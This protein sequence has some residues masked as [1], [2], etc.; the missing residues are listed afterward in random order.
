[1]SPKD[2][3]VAYRDVELSA[4]EQRA[5]C[6]KE[7]LLPGGHHDAFAQL[8]EVGDETSVPYLIGALRWAPAPKAGGGVEC[9]WSHCEAALRRITNTSF[10]LGRKAWEQWWAAHGKEPRTRWLWDGFVARGHKLDEQDRK[11]TVLALLQAASDDEPFS[12]ANAYYVL[13]SLFQDTEVE[14]GLKTA[15]ASEAEK[16]RKGAVLVLALRKERDELRSYLDDPSSAVSEMARTKMDELPPPPARPNVVLTRHLGYDIG[17]IGA[18]ES[19]QVLYFGLETKQQRGTGSE[20]VA[21]SLRTKEVIWRFACDDVVTSV[22]KARDGKVYLVSGNHTV[23]C[24]KQETGQLTWQTRIAYDRRVRPDNGL[25]L[26]DGRLFLAEDKRFLCID[27]S[28]GRVVWSAAIDPTLSGFVWNEAAIFVHTL[29]NELCALSYEGQ[30]LRRA[31]VGFPWGGLALDGDT[32]YYWAEAGE[33]DS[34]TKVEIVACD[35]ATFERRWATGVGAIRNWR[36]ASPLVTEDSVIASSDSHVVAIAKGDGSVRWSVQDRADTAIA[37]YGEGLLLMKTDP[38]EVA[39][40]DA[41]TGELVF[42]L[43]EPGVFDLPLVLFPL[44]VFGDMDGDLWIVDPN[45]DADRS[46]P[47]ATQVSGAPVLTRS[48]GGRLAS[49]QHP[50]AFRADG[51]P[52]RDGPRHGLDALAGSAPDSGPGAPSRS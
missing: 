48:K 24:L 30:V 28:N 37:S 11:A 16:V 20:L 2:G 42:R 32:L 22:P 18:D 17:E 19:Q 46:G 33:A 6:H 15:S 39:L 52:W 10:G 47:E 26:R 14:E 45:L 44:L 8:I 49:I 51:A 5:R 50:F 27:A 25:I 34:G 31:P 12:D 13:T 29:G 21:F 7:L 4:E 9:T 35:P 41:A 23:Y 38:S 1:M 36:N 43:D 3:L 40:R